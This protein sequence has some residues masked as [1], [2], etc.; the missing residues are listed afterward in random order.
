[1]AFTYYEIPLSGVA[2]RF[3]VSLGGVSYSMLLAWRETDMGGWFLDI[4]AADATPV[5]MGIPLVTGADLLAQYPDKNFGGVL[6]VTTD[7]DPD[8]VP[9]YANIGT[10]SHVY[11]GVAS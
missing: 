10:Q 1:M 11:F 8:A 9:T 7:G 3:S 2:Q 6:R 4:L 5:L